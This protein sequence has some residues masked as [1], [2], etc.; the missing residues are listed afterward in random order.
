MSALK[1]SLG[2]L[3]TEKIEEWNSGQR[4]AFSRGEGL[5]LLSKLREAK[6]CPVSLPPL[7]SHS[8]HQTQLQSEEKRS[9]RLFFL[10]RENG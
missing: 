7:A 3:H 9:L 6:P 2:I 1:L 4:H 8:F 5:V 10:E